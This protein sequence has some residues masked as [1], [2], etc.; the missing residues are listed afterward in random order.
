MRSPPAWKIGDGYFEITPGSGDLAGRGVEGVLAPPDERNDRAAILLIHGGGWQAGDK[1]S[2]QL[3][4]RVFAEA[5]RVLKPGGSIVHL[6]VPPMTQPAPRDNVAVKPAPVKSTRRAT[7]PS[8]VP[9]GAGTATRFAPMPGT[10]QGCHQDP[11]LGQMAGSCE[12]CHGAATFALYKA[13]MRRALGFLTPFGG[14]SL[15]GPGA[16]P[17]FPV[18]GALIGAAVSESCD[19]LVASKRPTLP[20]RT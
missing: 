16:L 1:S 12:T 15:P 17:W 9:A 14:P 18:V 11:H 10:C 8:K 4:P 19:G 20:S 7:G 3:K 13:S 5:F 6:S 2:V